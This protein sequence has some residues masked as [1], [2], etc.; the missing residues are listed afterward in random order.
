LPDKEIDKDLRPETW[1]LDES[2]IATPPMAIDLARNEISR[3]AKLLNRMLRAVII[4]F[5]SDE[6]HIN[7]EN[8]SKE[9]K[10]LLIKEI[11]TRDEYFPQISLIQGIDMREEKIDFLDDKIRDYLIQIAKYS[12]SSEQVS[13]V[14]GMIS[15]A[16]DME[17]MADIIH[18]N[19]L[20]LIAKKKELSDDFSDEGKEELMIYHQ[21]V[22]RQI[23]LL[24]E[25]FAEVD[26]EKAKE[27]MAGER[28][29][30]DL[31]AQ[32]RVR[33]LERVQHN[34]KESAE[35]HEVHMELMDLMKQ[36]IVYS[37]NIAK[38]FLVKGKT[39]DSSL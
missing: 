25:S 7:R 3:M 17:S 24:R 10:E 5:M 19:M 28:K 13:E 33:H 20:P 27:I 34:R 22:C 29:Y 38:T 39:P 30:L 21:K 8:L 6:K 26:L 32:Y 36:I 11:P 15:M 2:S 18:R 12:L 37:S 23:D 31:E 35:T 9:E 1:Y 4:P 16:N 14:Y